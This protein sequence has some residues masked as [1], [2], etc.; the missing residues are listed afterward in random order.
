MSL[1][2]NFQFHKILPRKKAIAQKSLINVAIRMSQTKHCIRWFVTNHISSSTPRTNISLSSFRICASV[3]LMCVHIDVCSAF[4]GCIHVKCAFRL[5]QHIMVWLDV[6][7]LS[8]SVL[9][10][11]CIHANRCGNG[12]SSQFVI[13]GFISLLTRAAPTERYRPLWCTK[14]VPF[15]A[16]SFAFWNFL[17]FLLRQGRGQQWRN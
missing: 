3:N 10:A 2:E 8:R 12:G 17:D 4:I 16:S 11:I 5:V 1:P 6:M 9:N 13:I 7:L 14:P 15:F